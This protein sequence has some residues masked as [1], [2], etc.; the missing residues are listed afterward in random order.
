[1]IS[2]RE[3]HLYIKAV[4]RN[5]HCGKKAKEDALKFLTLSVDEFILQ[6]NEATINDMYN[7]FGMPKE[8]AKTLRGSIDTKE[9][10]KSRIIKISVLCFLILIIALLLVLLY[11][12]LVYEH[13]KVY[14]YDIDYDYIP[15]IILNIS[16]LKHI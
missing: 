7:T 11:I 2:E 12:E 15:T 3:K 8:A 4:S 5:I 14:Y 13:N 9:F 1:M 6:N 10:K 16:V